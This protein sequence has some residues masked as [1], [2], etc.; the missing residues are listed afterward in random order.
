MY[1]VKYCP[2]LTKMKRPEVE[3]VANNLGIITDEKD[4]NYINLRGIAPRRSG[5][6]VFKPLQKLTG[7]KKYYT[8]KEQKE[9]EDKLE[10]QKDP[11]EV[12]IIKTDKLGNK[13]S[14]F[15]KLSLRDNQKEF[16]KKM[17]Y[18][19]S[20]GSIAFWGVGT[21]KT[22]LGVMTIKLYLNY[23]P[24]GRVLFVAPSGLLSNL[25]EK[26]YL[27]GLDIQ[28]RRI[29]YYSFE[30]Y[31]RIKK[32][33]VNTL[34]MVD[35]A[36]NLRT[37]IGVKTIKDKE[38][39]D[40]Q[41]ITGGRAKAIIDYCSNVAS[42]VLLLTA[43]PLINKPYDMENLLAMIDGRPEMKQDFFNE[44]LSNKDLLID[45]FKNRVSWYSRS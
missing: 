1:N 35:E 26:L 4:P 34:L 25:V 8:E 24:N 15:D 12:D 33:C 20:R 14:E 18:S 42:K 40:K 6:N 7:V 17:I 22:I 5:K 16:I 31:S 32:G 21:G 9:F 23:Y 44:I 2:P 41:K 43:T 11:F 36:H 37:E 19:N 3:K 38:G 45:Y 29:E 13:T 10:K 28:D 27:F 39:K 30:R